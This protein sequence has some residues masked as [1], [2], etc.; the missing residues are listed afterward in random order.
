MEPHSADTAPF[1]SRPPVRSMR[2]RWTTRVAAAVVLA[3]V[4]LVGSAASASV[5]SSATVTAT[6]SVEARPS[7]Y[8]TYEGNVTSIVNSQRRARGLAQL[9]IHSSLTT[10]ARGHSYDMARMRRMTHTGSDGSNPGQRMTRA[11]FRWRAWGEN[12]AAG[13]TRSDSVMTAWMKSTYHRNNILNPTFR[14]IGVY[15]YIGGG[16][17]WWTMDLAA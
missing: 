12:V 1:P 2:R 6:V 4:G 11:G 17:W 3:S 8:A 10:A 13:Y 9:S 15:V 5:T 7:P 16:S 14:Y